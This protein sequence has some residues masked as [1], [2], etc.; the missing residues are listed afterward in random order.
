M[1]SQ[2]RIEVDFFKDA[3]FE[4]I[5]TNQ[6]SSFCE[7]IVK[8]I[9]KLRNKFP[10]Y[11]KNK[12][13]VDKFDKF[14]GDTIR[15]AI[16]DYWDKWKNYAEGWFTTHTILVCY[17]TLIDPYFAKLND[18]D[19]NIMLW[20]ALLHDIAK[21]GPPKFNSRDFIH[22]FQSARK[23]L[24]IFKDELNL[25]ELSKEDAIKWDEMIEVI[26]D[27]V[28]EASPEEFPDIYYSDDWCKFVH[29]HSKLPDIFERLEYFF[30][31]SS[32]IM[33]VIK[34]ILFHQ[35]INCL[36][37]FPNTRALKIEE[38]SKFMDDKDLEFQKI[39]MYNDTMSYELPHPSKKIKKLRREQI[40][41]K[42]DYI[43]GELW[44]V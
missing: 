14:Y 10:R 23:A 2:N 16:G 22:P 27:S 35:S 37:D 1:E 24:M 20:M 7:R 12:D 43:I 34:G 44:A 13:L 36:P 15:D 4:N 26:R 42:I 21:N 39:M 29:D 31:H 33:R 9:D 28:E 25:F 18:E 41:T 17:C 30:S 40:D 19:K 38:I 11:W 5:F 6:S 3:N 8:D 32:S